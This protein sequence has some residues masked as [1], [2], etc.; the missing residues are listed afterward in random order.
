MDLDV[1]LYAFF[2]GLLPTSLWLWFWLKEDSAHPEPRGLIFMTFVAGMVVVIFALPLQKLVYEYVITHFP[3]NTPLLL[4]F[5]ALIEEALKFIAAYIVAMR[6]RAFDEPIDAVIYMVT[7]AL[8]FSALENSL[9]LLD[10][11]LIPAGNLAGSIITGNMRFVGASILHVMTSAIVGLGLAFSFY[12]SKNIQHVFVLL[13]IL[14]AT[15]L[16]TVFN[17][18]IISNGGNNMLITFLVLWFLVIGLLLFF[19]KIKRLKQINTT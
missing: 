13:S 6:S 9:Y 8:G 1:L 7:V 19:E 12:K 16:H 14:V 15:A 4:A 2:G 18:A 17:L 5:L 10:K 11:D 3:G